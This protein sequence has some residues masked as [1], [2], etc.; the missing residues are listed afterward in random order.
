MSGIP[1]TYR[2]ERLPVSK[3]WAAVRAAAGLHEA[4]VRDE[5]LGGGDLCRIAGAAGVGTTAYSGE[6]LPNLS[7]TSARFAGVVR[8]GRAGRRRGAG[9]PQPFRGQAVPQ[10]RVNIGYTFWMG[11]YP[12]TR[13]EFTVFVAA[14]GHNASGPCWGLGGDG[15]WQE[16]QGSDWRNPGFAQG[17][18]HPVVCVSSQDAIAYLDWLGRT[19]GK[20]YRL[21]SEAEWEYVARAGTLTARFWGDG[22]DEA[23]RHANA[24]DETFRAELNFPT[25]PG[26]YFGCSVGHV[27]TSPVDSFASNPWVSTTCW[28]T[29]GNG[30]RIA[31]IRTIGTRQQRV[32]LGTRRATVFAT[33][34]SGAVAPGTASFPGASARRLASGTPSIIGIRISVSAW[35]E[36]SSSSILGSLPLCGRVWTL[37]HLTRLCALARIFRLN[38]YLL[39][40]PYQFLSLC[41]DA[42]REQNNATK[43]CCFNILCA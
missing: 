1:R 12:V 6:G 19:T 29:S 20:T 25:A 5:V 7:R 31:G 13:D 27:H 16:F 14:T 39:Q 15:S 9:V 22:R 21:P 42:A 3:R 36:P 41:R 26:R 43:P 35:P 30:L 34:A 17:G 4:G 37:H 32:C 40:S 24:A 23:C 11:R 10:H 2:L 33:N 38:L 18:N 28:E 8:H